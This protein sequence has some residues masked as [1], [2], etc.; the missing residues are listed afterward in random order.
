MDANHGKQRLLRVQDVSER[1]GLCRALVYQ[2]VRDGRFP[3]PVH[4]TSRA[5]AWPESDVDAWI[6]QRI[7]ASLKNRTTGLAA[8]DR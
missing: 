4:I 1:I 6:E 5:V 2:M 8:G 7:A 3:P